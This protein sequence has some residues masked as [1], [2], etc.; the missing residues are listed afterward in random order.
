MTDYGE[1]F[2]MN[3]GH[4]LGIPAN[5]EH[6][7]EALRHRAFLGEPAPIPSADAPSDTHDKAMFLKGL[8]IHP[9]VVS[10]DYELAE[11]ERRM[12]A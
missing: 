12:E 7:L 11:I 2:N 4:P 8:G 1:E 3:L 10:L 5:T 6:I 9:G